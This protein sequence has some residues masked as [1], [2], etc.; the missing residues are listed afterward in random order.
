MIIKCVQEYCAV[1][2][3]VIQLKM[4]VSLPPNSADFLLPRLVFCPGAIRSNNTVFIF[5]VVV[6]YRVTL[7]LTK[8]CLYSVPRDPKAGSH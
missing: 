6:S 4:S 5:E 7:F 8:Y 3:D 1:I 2:N